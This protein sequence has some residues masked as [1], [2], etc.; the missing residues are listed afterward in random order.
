MPQMKILCNCRARLENKGQVTKEENQGEH[1]HH[2]IFSNRETDDSQV[3][4]VE[5]PS[6]IC[7]SLL[8]L[9]KGHRASAKERV[10]V[11]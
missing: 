3:D 5:T 6:C 9:D 10:S 7:T 2:A 8:V 11:P 1:R 4:L